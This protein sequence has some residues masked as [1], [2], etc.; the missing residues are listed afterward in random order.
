MYT[1]CHMKNVSAN[2]GKA[3]W[4]KEYKLN[5]VYTFD[6]IENFWRLDNNITRVRDI[7]AN[8][9]YLLFKHGITPE[10]EDPRNNDGGK[11][12]VTIPIEKNFEKELEE[13]WQRIV[14]MM[15]GA[16]ID[17]ELQILKIY[18]YTN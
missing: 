3:R 17:K 7:V 9:D 13:A 2:K 10:W 14:L 15:I 12:V 5:E 4:Q 6:S 8:T 11:W 16:N 1:L 18:I